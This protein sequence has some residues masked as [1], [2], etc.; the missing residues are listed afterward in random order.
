LPQ[1]RWPQKYF[2]EL[3]QKILDQHP[4]ARILLTGSPEEARE[5]DPIR[6]K[7]GRGGIF[8]L[9]GQF[10]FQD[11]PVLYQ[12]CTLMISND[13]GPAHFAS[14]T[15]LPIFVFFGPETPHLYGAL[16]NFTPLYAN[17]ACSP[18]V[19]AWNHRK[20]PCR[21]N[22]CLQVITPDQVYEKIKG[23]LEQV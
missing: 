9:C 20:T 13:S 5:V 2:V 3:A 17:L 23:L 21:D 14:I 19:S 16:G 18:C 10:A 1:R 11:L 7:A 15:D 8:N 4:N 22:I 12:V 6:V